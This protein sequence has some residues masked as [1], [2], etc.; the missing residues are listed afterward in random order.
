VP[1]SDF[2]RAL[3]RELGAP[4]ALT[5]ANKSGGLSS[6]AVEEFRELWPLVRLCSRREAARLLVAALPVRLRV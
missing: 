5:S 2:V 3:A 4:L 6:I 1:N